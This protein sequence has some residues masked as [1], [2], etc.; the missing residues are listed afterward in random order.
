[1][2][3]MDLAG[4]PVKTARRVPLT[5]WFRFRRVIEATPTA[6]LLIGEHPCAQT[7]ASLGLKM[8]GQ[9]SPAIADPRSSTKN[10]D[11]I[12]HAHLL[13]GL[14]LQM[15]LLRARTD[16]KPMQSVTHFPSKAAW[17]G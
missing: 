12:T 14:Q 13:E 8:A 17:T 10:A 9:D 5:T 7:C 2:V 11:L 16:R 3:V 1:M 4:V 6:L 15:E